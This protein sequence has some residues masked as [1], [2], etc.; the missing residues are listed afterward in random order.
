MAEASSRTAS[1]DPA[2]PAASWLGFAIAW[3]IFWLFL[4]TAAVHEYLR[5]GG[6]ELWQPL[7]WE[8]SSMA[9]AS[10]IAWLQWR[11]AYRLIDLL[12][13]PWRWYAASVAPLLIAA[14][15]FVAAVYAIRHGIYALLGQSYQHE[16]WRVVFTFEIFKFSLF[17][18]MFVAIA[19]GIQSHHAMSQARLRLERERQLAQRA[20]LLQL[21]QQIEPHFLF[22]ALNTI[23]ETIHSDPNLADN[24]LTKLATLLRAATDLARKPEAKLDEELLL[25]QAYCAI[26]RQRFSDRVSVEFDIDAAAR[27]WNLPTLL[28]Q[29]L[30]EN[31]FRHGVE[32]HSQPTAIVVRA[33]L[34]SA[35]L[36]IEVQDNTGEL[37]ADPVF[38]VG[39]TNLRQRLQTRYG[40]RAQLQLQRADGGGVIASLELPCES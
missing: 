37:P 12:A 31:A 21:A 19:F 8:G 27:A 5:Q 2:R 14:P 33:R 6:R 18:L 3:L 11:Q 25:L 35:R 39:L 22:N 20:Q 4:M 9:V 23:T 34:R 1:A 26:M 28:L 36:R 16:P 7:L 13:T 17:Y 24:L 38:G 30:L 32:K 10:V 29:P 40:D 15:A